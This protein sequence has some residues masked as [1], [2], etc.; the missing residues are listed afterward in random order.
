MSNHAKFKITK[1]KRVTQPEE[2]V[3]CPSC[4]M[5]FEDSPYIKVEA[6]LQLHMR[7]RPTCYLVYLDERLGL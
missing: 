4:G 3:K 5:R 1:K 6:A 2:I 7:I